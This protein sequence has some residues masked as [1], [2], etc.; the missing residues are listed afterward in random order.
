MRWTTIWFER[1]RRNNIAVHR[2]NNLARDGA[3]DA[4]RDRSNSKVR[5][6]A[7]ER[8]WDGFNAIVWDTTVHIKWH[9]VMQS[10]AAKTFNIKLEM[11]VTKHAG[12]SKQSGCAYNLILTA[13]RKSAWYVCSYLI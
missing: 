5:D 12:M 3:V 8:Q 10:Q 13:F 7:I 9:A 6:K 2:T 4:E 11:W 1:D